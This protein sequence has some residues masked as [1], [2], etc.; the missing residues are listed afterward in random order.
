MA[1]KRSQK[2]K[3][4]RGA[5]RARKPAAS[6][7]TL[8]TCFLIQRVQGGQA[9]Q[10]V[11]GRRPTIRVVGKTLVIGPVSVKGGEIHG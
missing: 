11:F 10:H 7:A 5:G 3:A 6:A 4:R 2:K 8:G 1:K 9:F